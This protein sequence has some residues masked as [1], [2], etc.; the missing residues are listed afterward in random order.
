MYNYVLIP[1]KCYD[2]DDRFKK[3]FR[4]PKIK[5]KETHDTEKRIT[6]II[7]RLDE[8]LL[9]EL[10]QICQYGTSNKGI[11]TKSVKTVSKIY[12]KDFSI[13]INSNIFLGKY[14]ENLFFVY[15]IC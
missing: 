10:A 13:I 9:D 14:V 3:H 15:Y 7:D 6:R 11:D 12:D 1:K 8:K 4:Y 2:L 5:P